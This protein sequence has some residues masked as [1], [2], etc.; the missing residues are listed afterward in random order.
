MPVQRCQSDGKPGYKWGASGHCYTYTAGNKESREEARHK[1]EQ[2]GAAIQ[3][4]Q[5]EEEQAAKQAEVL[6]L[7]ELD[8]LDRK[9][10]LRSLKITTE[11]VSAVTDNA[12]G[13]ARLKAVTDEEWAAAVAADEG[14]EG[15]A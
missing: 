7:D 9:A 3:L 8:E 15:S 10:R 1:A 13:L 11:A 5:Q 6:P 14:E 4:H 12:D 2:Q